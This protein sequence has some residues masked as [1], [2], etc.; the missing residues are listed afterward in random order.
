MR[1]VGLCSQQKV[2][3]KIALK[4]M[5]IIYWVAVRLNDGRSLGCIRVKLK[6]DS[7]I[8]ICHQSG[9]LGEEDDREQRE[10]EGGT[11]STGVRALMSK[12]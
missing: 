8:L 1:G 7:F 9:R 2:T 4:F 12:A 10:T 3:K 5:I 6:P 11:K